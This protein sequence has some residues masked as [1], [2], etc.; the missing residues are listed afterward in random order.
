MQ[1]ESIIKEELHYTKRMHDEDN[2][3]HTATMQNVSECF[4]IFCTCLVHFAG[5]FMGWPSHEMPYGT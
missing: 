2:V 4:P 3:L 5:H 1:C